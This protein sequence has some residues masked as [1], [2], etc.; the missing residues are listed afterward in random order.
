MQSAE[1]TQSLHVA[2]RARRSHQAPGARRHC[3]DVRVCAHLIRLC[4]QS[5][6][7]AGLIDADNQMGQRIGDEIMLRGLSLKFMVEL[8]ERFSDV[9]FRLFVIRSAK[10]D[11]PTRTTL[12]NGVSGNKMIDTFNS[13]RFTRLFSK[14][15]KVVAR[16]TGTAGALISATG[17]GPSGA[18][19]AGEDNPTLS[20]ATRIMKIWIPGRKF[21][22]G[23]KIQ[24]EQQGSQVKFFDYHII[25]FAYSNYSTNQDVWNVARIND[26]VIQLYYKDA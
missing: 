9:T 1:Q 13:E 15:F 24:Y 23:G 25:L 17:F 26:A 8:N 4:M 10:G 6:E 16:N 7:L 12:F 21:G 11:T 22:R 2:L 20:R 3:R 19:I 14:T 5:A 18:Y